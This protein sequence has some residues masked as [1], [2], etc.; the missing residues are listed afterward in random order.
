LQ[1]VFVATK[2]ILASG[3]GHAGAYCIILKPFL[4]Y[5]EA[6]P[7]WDEC[8]DYVSHLC[9]FVKAKDRERFDHH[10]LKWLVRAVKTATMPDSYN[11]QA[12]VLVSNRQNSGKSTFCRFLCPKALSAYI[13]ENIGTDKDSHVAITEN[14]LIN[15]DELSQAEK[16]EIKA[17]KS[18]FSKDKVKARLTYDKRASIHVR[19]ASFLGSTDKWEFLTDE[20]GSVRW[21]CM[22]IDYI[23]WNYSKEVDMDKVYSMVWHLAKDKEFVS[24]LTRAEIE[25]NDR[26][27]KKF[28]VSSAES[29]LID[30]FF[31][32]AGEDDGGF[33]YNATEIWSIL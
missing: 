14:F 8:T 2:S 12:F 7:E 23:D 18:M 20:N 29:D 5:F 16:A 28:Q 13:A 31:E 33:F 27:N 15:L 25:E 22:E 1:K 26:V 32:P 21:L 17:F 3:K 10:L 30:R 24:E 11:K 19:R 6:L 4:Q 9:S